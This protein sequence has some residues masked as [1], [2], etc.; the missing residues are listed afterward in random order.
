MTTGETRPEGEVS[1]ERI[2]PPRKI[3][4]V[5]T[6]DSDGHA[7][8]GLRPSKLRDGDEVITVDLPIQ[9]T[10]FNSPYRKPVDFESLAKSYATAADEE[11]RKGLE[12]PNFSHHALIADGRELPFREETFD[13]VVLNDVIGDP[14]LDADSMRRLIDEALRVLKIGGEIWAFDDRGKGENFS[15]FK[16]L[17]KGD[18]IMHGVGYAYEDLEDHSGVWEKHGKEEQSVYLEE[19]LKRRDK[20]ETYVNSNHPN[21]FVVTK[22]EPWKSSELSEVPEVVTPA[23][24][25]GTPFKELLGQLFGRQ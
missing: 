21:F 12:V 19:K 13:L 20:M 9:Y 16:K 18:A 11:R 15:T 3:L 8:A 4:E 7:T 25:T 22:T 1:R 24:R 6:I 5:G 14:G 2:L 23:P 17:M 10:Y